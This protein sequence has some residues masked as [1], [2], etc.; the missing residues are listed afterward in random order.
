MQ[1]IVDGRTAAQQS[2]QGMGDLQALITEAKSYKEEVEEMHAKLAFLQIQIKAMEDSTEY[3]A[4]QKE[5]LDETKK[6]TEENNEDLEKQLK[7][8][9]E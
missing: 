1:R 8:K 2:F 3:L 9:E 7:V 4:S 6:E 5:V